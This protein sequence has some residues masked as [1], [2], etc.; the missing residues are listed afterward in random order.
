MG[1]RLYPIWILDHPNCVVPLPNT[2]GDGSCLG[3]PYNTAEC[4][5]DADD[6]LVDGYPNCH[7][8]RPDWIGNDICSGGDT[9]RRNVDGMVEINV[10]LIYIK[11]DNVIIMNASNKY[12]I[13][14]IFR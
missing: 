12:Y 4:G 10:L 13:S 5:W 9:I 2:L 7:V 11:Y 6:C 8:D 1:W 3:K 14:I